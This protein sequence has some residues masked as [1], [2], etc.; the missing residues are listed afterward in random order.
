MRF[1]MRPFLILGSVLVLSF[2][3]CSAGNGDTPQEEDTTDPTTGAGGDS[4][5]AGTGAGGESSGTSE[6]TTT[7]GSGGSGM[8]SSDSGAKGGSS[9]AGGNMSGA[10]GMTMM[11][12]VDSGPPMPSS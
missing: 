7:T 10:G 11:M 6:S 9:N 8:S 4:T 3:G 12:A 2:A 1:S 5:N